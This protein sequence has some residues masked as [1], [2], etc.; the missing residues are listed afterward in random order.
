MLVGECSAAVHFF[1]SVPSFDLILAVVGGNVGKKKRKKIDADGE[2]NTYCSS[3]KKRLWP[4]IAGRNGS[5][6]V[7][8]RTGVPD[9]RLNLPT[10][11]IV[12]R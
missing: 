12:S 3:R 2:S 9:R 4:W 8:A 5:K 6:C 1:I 10:Q 11:D 7:L